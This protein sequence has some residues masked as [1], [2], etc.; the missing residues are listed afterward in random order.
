M[1]SSL[2]ALLTSTLGEYIRL[3]DEF[4]DFLVDLEGDLVSV[5]PLLVDLTAEEDEF[6][7]SAERQRPECRLMPYSVTMRR[8]SPVA[9]SMSFDA[10]VRLLSRR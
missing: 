7:L 8:A 9:R 6:F 2:S 10:P 5:V 4:A 1:T 3:V